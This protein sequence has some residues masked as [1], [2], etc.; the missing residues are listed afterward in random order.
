MMIMKKEVKGCCKIVHAQTVLP[1]D[2]LNE[3]LEKTGEKTTKDA[4]YKAVVH[5]LECPIAGGGDE[6]SEEEGN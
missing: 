5:Y 6:K 3:L 2:L 1:L 4:L